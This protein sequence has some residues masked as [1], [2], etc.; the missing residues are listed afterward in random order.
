M[1]IDLD[2]FY[3][4]ESIE[5]WK[6]VLG[7]ELH[8]HFG[9]FQTND[10]FETGLR[11]AVRNFYPYIPLGARVLDIGCGWGGPAKLLTNEQQCVVQGITISK[12]QVSYC[13]EI[14]LDVW[15]C[16]VEQDEIMGQYDVILM[17]EL[18]SHIQDK[19]TLLTKLHSVAPRL[20]ISMNCLADNIAGSRS[21]F[22]DSMTLI[23]ESEFVT[24][25]EETGW[26]IV[27]KQNRRFQALPTL[28]YWKKNLERVYSDT[29]PPGQLNLLKKLTD[30]ALQS[31]ARWCQMNPLIDIVAEV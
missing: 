26:R 22:G 3:S 31:P 16:D 6:Q 23:T 15:Q 14:G 12:R 10:D 20:I 5:E 18:L 13:R 8:Y 1:T 28:F 9:Y 17:L 2:T 21:V 4:Q 19:K 24:M 7:E 27:F 11:Q 25:L 29:T 30:L